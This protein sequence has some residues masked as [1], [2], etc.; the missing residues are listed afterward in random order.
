MG[1]I[2]ITNVD[3]A[4]AEMEHCKKLG[5]KGVLLGALPNAK[6]Y[7]TPEDD[8][9]WAA[10]LDL[11]M[12]V[13]AHVQ[14]YRTGARANQPTMKYP[15][16]DPEVMA[17]LR[18]PFLEWLVNFGLPPAVGMAQL[19]LSGVFERFHTAVSFFHGA[20]DGQKGMNLVMLILIG[21]IPNAYA[22]NQGLPPSQIERFKAASK[23]ASK[24]ISDKASGYDIIGDPR[25]AVELYVSRHEID[26]GTF[27]S[28]A[29]LVRTVGEELKQ[30]G[31]IAKMPP[32]LVA[33]VRNDMYLAS[34]SLR[35]LM[36]D[37]SSDLNA[38][39]IGK[40]REYQSALDRA[41]KFIPLWVKIVVA[42]VLGSGTMIGWKR[43]VVTV[44]EKIGK[45][46]LTYAQGASA[47]VVAM[48]TIFAADNFGLPVSTTHILTSGVA[49]TMA[50]NG[51]GLQ[52]GTVRSLAMAWVLTLPA[53]ITLSGVLFFLFSRVL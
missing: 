30:Y 14:L 32:S 20:N 3:D 11:D 18:R 42:I 27:P 33:A 15:K 28:L 8:R 53:A 7:P 38:D 43:I 41:T 44:G 23:A 4:I 9:F 22:L 52:W 36:R 39:D 46:H 50:A 17:R 24:V 51:S 2:P 26:E 34:E 29:V 31:S 40:L 25:S 21:T 35:L 13:T 1:V 16:E 6:G 5:L 37:R 49:G 12:P 19:V 45:D 48:F 10:A 47:E